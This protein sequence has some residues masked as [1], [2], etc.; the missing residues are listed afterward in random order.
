MGT[1][2]L[3]REGVGRGRFGMGGGIK[4]LWLIVQYIEGKIYA[5]NCRF[6]GVLDTCGYL[7]QT[8]KL[9]NVN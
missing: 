1:T 7:W 2:Y 3:G 4:P 5:R 6:L 8:V 9:N